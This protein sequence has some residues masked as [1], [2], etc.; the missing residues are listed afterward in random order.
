MEKAIYGLAADFEAVHWDIKG[1]NVEYFHV[2]PST[3]NYADNVAFTLE[4]EPKEIITTTKDQE[5]GQLILVQ[6]GPLLFF[7]F[8]PATKHGERF[9]RYVKLQRLRKCSY[10]FRKILSYRD[11]HNEKKLMWAMDSKEKILINHGTVFEICLTNS[12][13]DNTTFCTTDVN[14]P[15]LKGINWITNV[16]LK[17]GSRWEQHLETEELKD[18]IEEFDLTSKRIDQLLSKN[19]NKILLSIEK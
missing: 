18:M 11:V 5:N 14:D 16:E 7:K 13:R 3:V 4:H 12:P 6:K 9:Y 1:K 8:V 2:K 10:I 17:G 19:Y 15:R